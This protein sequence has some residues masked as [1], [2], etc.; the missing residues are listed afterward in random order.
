MAVEVKHKFVS[1]KADGAD[2]TVVRPSNW[3][4]DH[5][6]TLASGRLLG[7]TTAGTGAAEE[8][9]AGTGL[10]LA[11]GT[12]SLGATSVTAGSYGDAA[13]VAAFTVDAQ[14]R[15]TAA[16]GASITPAAIGAA[17]SSH[18]HVAADVT[19]F[20]EA[21]DDRVAALLVA[22]SNITLSYNDGAGTL[23][24]AAAGSAT[25][26]SYTASTRVLASS[27][28]ADATLPLFSSGDA[29]L[30]PASG[31]GTSNFLRADGTWAAPPGGG[32][33]S[34]GGITGTLSAQTDLQSALDG[35]APSSHTQ[36]W[37]TIT[38]TPTT[39]GGYGITDAAPSSRQVASG[40]GL[41]GGGD[42]SADRTLALTGQ[43]LALHNLGTSGVIARTGAGTVAA[44]TIT[45]G[46]NISVTNG[47]GVAGNPTVAVTGLAAVATSGSASDLTT[48]SLALARIAQSGATSGQV[49][50]WNGSA[51]APAAD[52]TGG[53]SA[54]DGYVATYW[55]APY[56]GTVGASAA[57]TNNLIRFVPFR[58]VRSITVV[59]LAARVTTGGTGNAQLAI[60]ASDTAEGRP[61]GSA[62]ISTGNLNVAS[63]GIVSETSLSPVT[64]NA[65]TV[66]W[67][68]M[69]TSPAS[70]NWQ[71]LLTANVPPLAQIVG[72]S[73]IANLSSG[74]ATL[75]TPLTLA[76]TFGTWPDVTSSS[77]TESTA[78]GQ[79]MVFLQIGTLP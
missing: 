15:L 33:V 74:V 58:L 71:A 57:L 78:N 35:K 64:L 29:G 42:L 11:G 55:L 4:D 21:V 66:Y 62:L 73:D 40:T 37:S 13:T 17:A 6:L 39:L 51:W 46:A 65:N 22:G 3:N 25:D 43:A 8:I 69:N 68:A 9:A 10:S 53:S 26:L 61:T 23:T 30:A 75:A 32:S 56:W 31:G 45:A 12:I 79:V 47:D 34:W 77:F 27:T 5:D 54:L 52:A 16:G 41:T 70:T 50:K 20:A 49:L 36:A 2:A 76:Q 18:A 59:G 1:A 60:Y 19:D 14:G 63:A 24:I 44:R 38:S 7:R 28:G 72:V 48:G 67:A